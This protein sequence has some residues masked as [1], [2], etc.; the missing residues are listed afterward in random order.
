M[1]KFQSRLFNW[2]DHSWPA[3]LG[4]NVRRSLDQKFRQ[5]SGMPLEE[6]PRLLAYQVAKAALYPVYLLSLAAKRTFLALNWIKP[7]AKDNL[8]SQSED[9]F[10]NESEANLNQEANLDQL[11][12]EPNSDLPKSKILFIFRPFV[13]FFDWI[14]QTRVELDRSITA[15]IKRSSD[16][17]ATSEKNELQ[18]KWIANQIF[19]EIWKEQI[20]KKQ[21][22]INSLRENNGLAENGSL[23]KNTKLEQLRHLIEAAIAYFFGKQTYPQN[24]GLPDQE[25]NPTNLNSSNNLNNSNNI[26]GS[27]PS[28]LEENIKS[29]IE[30][31][32]LAENNNL[33]RLRDLIAAAIDYFV[34]KRS[35]DGSQTQNIDG[36]SNIEFDSPSPKILDPNFDQDFDQDFDQRSQP[37]NYDQLKVDN[38]FERLQKIIEAAIAYFFGKT[39]PT[40]EETSDMVTTDQAL[41]TMEELFNND[42]GPWPLPLEYEAISYS[43]SPDRHIIHSSGELQNFETTTSQISQ[44]QLQ[45]GLF[46]EEE[47]LIYQLPNAMS[48]ESDRPLRAWIEANST[49]LGYVY[50]PVMAVVYGIDAIV[51][52]VENLMIKFWK[53]LIG[54]PK[55]L[56]HFIRYGKS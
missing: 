24:Y 47:D 2:I 5:F 40:L 35:L 39:K 44:D 27:N 23:D 29:I 53:G 43:K 41:S 6:L 49:I 38:Q 26:F 3:Q 42:N 14:L 4:Q 45:G 25:T 34:G 10:L 51:L 46:A 12:I 36:N 37:K 22:T 11:R 13:R 20:E 8:R 32:P 19:A 17:L 21:S 33:Q 1:P 30:N 52:K 16:N 7:A 56:I 18:T 50:N 48:S 55:R 15:I 31:S 54:F 9:K 28:N